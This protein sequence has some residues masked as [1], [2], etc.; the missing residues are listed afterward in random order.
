MP[1]DIR[2]RFS[3]K[4]LQPSTYNEFKRMVTQ[5]YPAYREKRDR[6]S[7]FKNISK[8]NSLGHNSSP[9]KES[10]SLLCL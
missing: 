1:Y 9:L 3:M 10:H 7:S 6:M 4:D 5:P 2:D 8:K